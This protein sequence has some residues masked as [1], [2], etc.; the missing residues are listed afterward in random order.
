[1]QVPQ[2]SNRDG[3]KK[4]TGAYRYLMNYL[5]QVYTGARGDTTT[6]NFVRSM[7]SNSSITN[8]IDFMRFVVSSSTSNVVTGS[9]ASSW[10]QEFIADYDKSL[11]DDELAQLT[12]EIDDIVI[13]NNNEKVYINTPKIRI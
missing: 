11:S 2:G 6:Q 10:L 8:P 9:R 7:I 12:N 4:E 5:Y 3:T 13:D 1:M